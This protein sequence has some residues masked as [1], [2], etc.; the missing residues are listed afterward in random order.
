MNPV[1]K[2]IL[3]FV[4]AGLCEI[5]GGY[6]VWR[7]WRNGGFWVIGILGAI[8]LVLYGIIPTYQAAHFGRVYAAYGGVFIILSIYITPQSPQQVDNASI[9]PDFY[10]ILMGYGFFLIL[11]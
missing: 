6:L 8:I 1:V 4:L 3:L 5:G 2:S 9:R 10:E 11:L 7:W